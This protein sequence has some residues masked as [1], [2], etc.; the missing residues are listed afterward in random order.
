VCVCVQTG[1]GL[2]GREVGAPA[3]A[4][5]GGTLTGGGGVASLAGTC[6]PLLSFGWS[7]ITRPIFTSLAQQSACSS[8]LPVTLTTPLAAVTRPWFLL[9]LG[10]R[11]TM[12]ANTRLSAHANDLPAS[13]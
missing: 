4:T 13:E 2:G 6:T 11:R 8:T 9:T 5:P 1:S 12:R 10:S 7:S 3:W